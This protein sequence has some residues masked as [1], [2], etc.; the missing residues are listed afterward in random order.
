MKALTCLLKRAI[1]GG[2]LSA[3]QVRGRGSE[4][5]A[6]ADDTLLFYEASQNQM[7]FLCWLL[8]WFEANSG[9]RVNLDKSELISVGR[10]E[11][12]E[13]LASELGCKV[14]SLPSTYL[15]MPLSAPFKSVVAWDR[16]E[17]RFHKRLA[18]W[19]WQYISKGGRITLIRST[20][21]SLPIYFMSIL[22]TDLGQWD[23]G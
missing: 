7:T 6:D 16:V 5:V 18:M 15:G 10:V 9:L 17:E 20:L 11:S 3:C 8:M 22:L 2:F 14:G 13:D 1:G 21:L 12:V 23:W 19:K 4:G